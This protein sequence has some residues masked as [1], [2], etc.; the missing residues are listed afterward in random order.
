MVFTGT[1]AQLKEPSDDSGPLY[2]AQE[3]LIKIEKVFKI[4]ELGDRTY[5]GQQY[6]RTDCFYEQEL[7]VG[8][9]ILVFCYDYEDDYAIPGN[10]SILKIE[11]F[12]D[13]AVA[14]IQRYIDADEDPLKIQED[15]GLW[16]TRNHGRALE[17]IVKCRKELASMPKDADIE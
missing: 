2:T 4:K 1:I 6:L 17:R 13:P 12:E 5:V 16:A 8:D 9:S 11:S 15:I 14:A 3:G 7:T 10:R